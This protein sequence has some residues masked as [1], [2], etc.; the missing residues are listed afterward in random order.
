LIEPAPDAAP[1]SETTAPAPSAT[2]AAEVSNAPPPPPPP[3]V[4]N[5]EPPTSKAGPAP[6]FAPTRPE[7]SVSKVAS[8]TVPPPAAAAAPGTAAAP[9]AALRQAPSPPQPGAASPAA[10]TDA[11]RTYV[12]QLGVFTSP[13][14]AEALQRK[15]TEGGVSTFTETRVLI[16]PFRDRAEADRS[17]E[18]VK[19]LGLGAVVMPARP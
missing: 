2:A 14:N 5:T 8:T 13:Q 19:K 16:G 1:A 17:M 10:K 11:S 7:T 6:R 9:A 4:I 15:L 3:E 12:V 18:I